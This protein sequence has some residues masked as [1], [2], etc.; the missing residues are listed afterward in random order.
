VTE[1]K[2]GIGQ[3]KASGIVL[4]FGY[5]TLLCATLMTLAFGWRT[6]RDYRMERWIET[7]AQVGRCR[8]DVSYPFASDGGGTLF[9]LHCDLSYEFASQQREYK[10]HT[11]SDRSVPARYRIED[12]VARHRPGAEITVAV[13]PSNPS[14]IVVRSPL[15]IHQFP[16]S[17][18]ALMTAIVFGVLGLLL[19]VIGR[20][21]AISVR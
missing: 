18:E 11:T 16:S 19:V 17:R 2:T 3:T 12:W 14:Q 1:R 6:Y 4:L 10:L 9:S 8:L 15:P 5:F 20:R 21:L 13:N 7:P